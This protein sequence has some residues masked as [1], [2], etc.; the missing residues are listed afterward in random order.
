MR[1]VKWGN[2][3]AAI[4]INNTDDV[5][6]HYTIYTHTHT[7]LIALYYIVYY[8]VNYDHQFIPQTLF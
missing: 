7:H 6:L 8:I 3:S 5:A 1:K 4:S 2:L